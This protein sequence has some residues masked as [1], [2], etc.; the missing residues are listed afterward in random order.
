VA[1]AGR[2]AADITADLHHPAVRA[3]EPE[4]LQ[5]EGVEARARGRRDRGDPRPWD[6]RAA[7]PLR[8]RPPRRR[9]LDPGA[10]GVPWPRRSGVHAADLQPPHAQHRGPCAGHCRR[11]ARSS[12]GILAGTRRVAR[13]KIRG[14][15]L[16]SFSAGTGRTLPDRYIEGTCPICAYDGRGDQCDNC[17]NQLE[18]T[19][20]IGPR[21]TIDRKPPDF[22]ETER[23]GPG[24]PRG[25]P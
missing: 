10:R 12:C 23:Y 7:A 19:D 21:S 6:A 11:R 4:L 18:P 15:M 16:G 8:L 17:G 24:G 3:A 20:L 5:P 22:R 25:L 13:S 14:S 2:R 1:G 9:D